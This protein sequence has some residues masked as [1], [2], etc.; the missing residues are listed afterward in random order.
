[1]RKKI[2]FENLKSHDEIVVGTMSKY[3]NL[4]GDIKMQGFT[5]NYQRQ[6]KL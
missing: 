3:E 6:Y 4:N 2:Y 1:M 5:E